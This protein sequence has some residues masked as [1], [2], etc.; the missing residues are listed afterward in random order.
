[1]PLPCQQVCSLSPANK[2][3]DSQAPKYLNHD[4]SPANRFAT[5]GPFAIILC[6]SMLREM[7]EDSKRHQADREVNGRI[8]RVVRAGGALDDVRWADVAV[9]DVLYVTEGQ[10]RCDETFVDPLS[11]RALPQHSE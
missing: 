1:M 7:W 10:V 8:T 2:V 3:R 4:L 6:L 9:G 5:A 11:A